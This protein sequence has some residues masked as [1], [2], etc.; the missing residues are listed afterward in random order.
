MDYKEG[1]IVLV[2]EKYLGEIKKVDINLCEQC[3]IKVDV[4]GKGEMLVAP[5]QLNHVDLRRLIV[6]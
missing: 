3:W 6:E 4:L 2:Y 5:E 1:D